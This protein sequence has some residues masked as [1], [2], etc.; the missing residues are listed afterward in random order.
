M[1]GRK[2]TRALRE[3]TPLHLYLPGEHRAVWNATGAGRGQKEWLLCEVDHRRPD[4]LVRGLPQRHVRYGVN[5]FTAAHW[6]LIDEVKPKR[7]VICYDNDDAG[8]SRRGEAGRGTEGQGHRRR[9]GEAAARQGHQRRG[10]R[11]QERADGAGDRPGSQRRRGTTP[12][13]AS[14]TRQACTV[15]RPAPSPRPVPAEPP[16][17]C[18][19][20]ISA[21]TCPSHPGEPEAASAAAEPFRPRLR[22][23]QPARISF[24]RAPAATASSASG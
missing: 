17:L 7:I 18:M 13:P 3:G 9:A 8:Q 24:S 20:L 4:A 6:A 19:P 22:R 14:C 21:G 16:K 15:A 12:A 2:I 11:Q 1:Y 10:P 5:G 23:V